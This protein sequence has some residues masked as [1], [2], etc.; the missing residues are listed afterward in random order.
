MILKM[1]RKDPLLHDADAVYAAVTAAARNAVF[2]TNHGV[3]DT[4]EGRFEALSL[5]VFLVAGRLNGLGEDGKAL[6]QAFID[7]FFAGL[8][9]A[10]R[11]IGIGDT[12]VGKKVKAYARNFYGR[13]EAYSEGLL[14]DSEPAL[15]E[16]AILRN[17]FGGA[18]S[19]AG[20]APAIAS[21]MRASAAKLAQLDLAR[22]RIEPKLFATEVL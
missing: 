11:A 13:V 21:Y 10:M 5:H 16:A 1:F 20:H 9:D 4:V 3:P 22:I 17:L 15:L 7:R 19:L 2:F 14:S 18:E 12:S 8:D 6:A